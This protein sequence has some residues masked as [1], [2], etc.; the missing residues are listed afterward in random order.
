MEWKKSIT[1]PVFK[2][3]IKTDPINYRGISLLS[4]TQ[5]LLTKIL[6][7][8]IEK[9]GISDE[10]Q[11]FRQNRSTTDAIFIVRQVVEKAIEYNKP[12]YM[13]FVDLKQAFDKVRLKDVLGLLRARRVNEKIIEVIKK[14]NTNNSSII[15]SGSIT[16]KEILVICEIRQGDS[17]SPTLFNLI[18]GEIIKEVKGTGVDYKL[19]RHGI[20]I[21]CYA[22]D[23][24]IIYDNEDSLQ[25]MLYRLETTANK[26][27][28]LISISKTE[29]LIISKEPKRCKLAVYNKSINEVM[30][31]K[32]LGVDITSDRCLLQKVKA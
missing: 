12:A 1:V 5:K 6:D 7:K 28:M 23:A 26:F 20:K 15:R 21:V 13:C 19:D 32:Y 9:T 17:I 3:G 27:G 18:M 4:S 14:L 30:K 16:T 8:E 10:Q 25:R 11:G 24:V 22:D 31:F 2:R 29:A